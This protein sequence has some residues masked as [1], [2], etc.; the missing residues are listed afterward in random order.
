MLKVADTVVVPSRRLAD[1]IDARFHREALIIPPTLPPL[2]ELPRQRLRSGPGLRVGWVGSGTHLGELEFLERVVLEF[3]ARR[4]DVTFV[5]AGPGIPRWARLHPRIERH[6]GF[7]LL[8]G[9]YR[10]LASLQ[11]D[12][13]LCPLLEYP[14]NEA[15][16]CLKPLEAAGLGIP[17][18]ASRVG[19]YAEDLEH[20]ETALLVAES[21]EAW[22]AALTRLMEDAELR[23]HL[24]A[25]GQAWAATRTIESTGPLWAKV[26]SAT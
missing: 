23:A 10:W 4:P 18:I 22:L 13:F 19:S 12:V 9:Y 21:T 6:L 7:M 25:G 11:L 8:P 26:W 20:E 1:V 2:C 3:L 5:V 15:K 16:P 14:W 17:V 24:A